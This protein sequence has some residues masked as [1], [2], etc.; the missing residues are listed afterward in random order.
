MSKRTPPRGDDQPDFFAACFA[1][2]P[3]RDQRDTMERPFFSL[4][5]KPR[6]IPIEYEVNGIYVHVSP[7]K[8]FG[9]ATIWDADILIWAATQITETLDRGL[10]PAKTIHF[11]P[12]NILKAIRRPTGGVNYKRLRAALRRLAATYV[13]TNI[14]ALGRRKI[15]GF[16]WLESWSETVDEEAGEPT[17]MSITLPDWLYSGIIKQGGVLSIHEDY[18]LLTG[19]IERWLY[20]VA[21]KHAGS[22]D[23][24]WQFTMRQLY[25]KSGSTARPSDFAIDVRKVVESNNLPEYT[26]SISRNKEGEEV[27]CM[28]R[29]SVLDPLDERYEIPRHPHRRIAGGIT[30]GAV[31]FTGRRPSPTLP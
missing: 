14:R 19:G 15:A 5:K 4:A 16:H 8:D 26:F 3:I 23:S 25:E 28:V 20:R 2:I 11:H 12:Y 22:Q 31:N 29:R 13:E 18:F 27:I 17:G 21:R 10:T 6:H 1:D 9:I 30:I 24:G 7:N